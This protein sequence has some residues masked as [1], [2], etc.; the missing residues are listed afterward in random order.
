MN[1]FIF[2]HKSDGIMQML[3]APTVQKQSDGSKQT[4]L[5]WSATVSVCLPEPWH[6][7]GSF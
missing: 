6:S 4:E 5:A 3:H 7:D 1:S 2:S